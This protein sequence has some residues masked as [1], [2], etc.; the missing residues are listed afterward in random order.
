MNNGRIMNRVAE[1]GYY[2]RY[3]RKVVEIFKSC[4]NIHI[5]MDGIFIFYI[6]LSYVLTDYSLSYLM[7][8]TFFSTI[9][10]RYRGKFPSQKL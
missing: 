7:L 6:L 3:V 5:H 1:K 9:S 10:R 8:E 4:R 2:V